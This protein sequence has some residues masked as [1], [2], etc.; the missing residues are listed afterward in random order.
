[1]DTMLD[2]A[3][4]ADSFIAWEDLQEGKHE[5]D[6]RNVLPPCPASAWLFPSPTAT[7]VWSSRARPEAVLTSPSN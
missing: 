2:R 4:T 6:G 7:R 1:M 5:F 3:W